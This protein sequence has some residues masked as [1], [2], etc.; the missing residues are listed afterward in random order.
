MTSP[1][2]SVPRP[3]HY[4]MD[5]YQPFWSGRDPNNGSVRLAVEDMIRSGLT[6]HTLMKAGVKLFNGNRQDLVDAIGRGRMDGLEI[7]MAAELAEFPSRD[8]QG[9]KRYSRFRLYPELDG[10]KYL[11]PI[12]APAMPWILPPVWELK[13][14]NN[15]PIW[16]TEG[17]K[18]AMKLL[19]HNEHAISLPGV[20]N[21]KAGQK[22]RHAEWRDKEMWAD[23]RGF[24]WDGRT[25]YLAFDSDLWTNPS[26]RFALYELGVRLYSLGALV[27]IV[28][29]SGPKGIDDY[30]APHPFVEKAISALKENARDLFAFMVPDHSNE[31]IRALAVI[32]LS[33]VK[34]DQLET[35][36]AK[37]LGISRSSLRK[38]VKQRRE[39]DGGL[40]EYLVKLNEKFA[41]IYGFSEIWDSDH[42]TSMKTMAFKDLHPY[43][44]K[45]WLEHHKKRVVKMDDIVFEPAGAKDH[46]INLFKGWPLV[47]DSTKVCQKIISHILHMAD[48]D[49]A[50]CHWMTCWLAWPLQHPGA[51][52]ATSLV[53]HGAQGTGKN[54]LF[55]TIMQIYGEYGATIDQKTLEADFTGWLSRKL[56]IVAD[57]VVSNLQ[58][59]QVKNRVKGLVT[60]GTVWINRK[61]IE[62]RPE[63]NH[64][65][66]VFL[67]NEDVPL[68]IDKD[69]RRFFVI[70]TDRVETKEYY[71]AIAAEI[72]AG[73]AAGLYDYLLKYDTSDFDGAHAKPMQTEAKTVLSALCERTPDKFIRAWQSGEVPVNCMSALSRQIYAV[74]CLWCSETNEHP[75]SENRFGRIM[76]KTF[77][78]KHTNL[79]T[80][81]EVLK[82]AADTTD[83]DLKF[84]QDKAESYRRAVQAVRVK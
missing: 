38:D 19:Q 30:L 80:I 15:V 67:S 14:K 45:R 11:H 40:P 39:H 22:D 43:D 6:I 55:D 82:P 84:F 65:N 21:F 23:L 36:V 51:K 7:G 63:A 4:D 3:I 66:L 49:E 64:S 18:K 78:K 54:I 9:G 5:L 26:V 35:A 8:E 81:Y 20:W 83:E 46:Q 32:E 59:V 74:Y 77:P 16:L 61:G 68:L 69:D 41:L 2:K 37:I 47:A 31:I 10:R 70:R 62:P 58:Q 44:G 57:E 76:G 73:G 13:A 42:A 60:G 29:W 33:P 50:A 52:M 25:V 1:L 28:V 34:S 12:G 72:S 24:R 71:Q 48:Y 79:G 56:F 75:S 17:E 27:R 53:I